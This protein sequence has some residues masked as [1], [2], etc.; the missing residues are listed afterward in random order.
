VAIALLQM[1]GNHPA[2]LT[3]NYAGWTIPLD[4]EP[5]HVLFRE[6]NL[7]PYRLS[8]RFTLRDAVNRYWYWLVFGATVLL[9]LG[10]ATL[11]ETRLNKRLK[12]A[13]LRLELQHELILNSVADGIYGVDR[14]GNSTFV[15][16]AM[17]EITGWKG[18]EII[19]HNQHEILHHTRADGSSHPAE[20]CPV[21]TTFR[22][23]APRYV[24]DD[25]FWKKD[26]TSFPVEYTCTPIRAEGGSV[27][28]SVVVFRDI[29]ERKETEER[30]LQHQLQLAHVARLSTLGEMASGIAHELNQPLTS[31]TMNA[32]ACVHMLDSSQT[33]VEACPDVMEKIAA[34]AQRAGEV[35]RQIR[36]FIRK[37]QPERQPVRVSNMVREVLLLIRADVRQAEVQVKLELDPIADRVL[38]QD[39]QIEQ[40]MLNLVL[41]AIEAMAEMAPGVRRLVIGSGLKSP[42]MVEIIVS[43]TGPGLSEEVTQ[44]LFTPFVTT[45]P[46]GLGLGLSISS[47][48]IDAHDSTLRVESR[49]GKGATFSFTLPLYREDREL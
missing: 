31:I 46:Q 37:D 36:H 5:V 48:I 29:T 26:G 20:E 3:G 38:A 30:T 19:G 49:P 41:N 9:F 43:D 8:T 24:E 25:L 32:R 33:A 15:N 12:M 18:E 23:N 7:P 22:D 4:Y 45:K 10:I 2:A 6:L 42:D 34:E 28:G 21:Y 14:S 16:R 17:E 13:K 44:R 47:G 11:W 27:L 40:V 39:I 1:P 35:I